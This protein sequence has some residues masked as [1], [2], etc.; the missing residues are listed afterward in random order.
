MHSENPLQAL[1]SPLGSA[2]VAA[3]RQLVSEDR[4][5]LQIM[6]LLHQQ[7]SPELARQ[8]LEQA[9]LQRRAAGKFPE[10]AERL[11]LLPDALEQASRHEVA[12]HRAARLADSGVT[13]IVDAGAGIGADTIAFAHHGIAVTAI[14]QDPHV[15]AAL[16]ANVRSLGLDVDVR[17]GDLQQILPSIDRTVTVYVDPARR[18]DGRRIF[19]PEQCR[20]PLSYL[21]SLPNP[22]VAKMSPGISYADLPSG[23]EA[24]WVSTFTEQGRSV[25][26]ACLWSPG[27][28][29][30]PRRAS[31]IARTGSV[32]VSGHADHDLPV[33][34]IG[35]YVYEPDGAINRAELAQHIA[36]PAR[37]TLIAPRI[38]Y[39]TADLAISTKLAA[40]FDVLD[41][42]PW[43]QRKLSAAVAAYELSDIVVKKRGIDLDP[44]RVRKALLPKKRDRTAEALVVIVCRRSHDSVAI[45]A[46]SAP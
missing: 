6:S 22:V 40:R 14:E 23:W 28:H 3:A 45:I 18:A 7:Y 33:G 30:A 17:V 16:R 32:S 46:R 9:I 31:I 1:L 43:S 44:A 4:T 11:I 2:A 10:F 13:R 12:N 20:P 5:T 34:P 29:S 39:L 27:L 15:A 38:G 8:A 21:Q 25:V 37:A 35:R 26:E 19:D 24:E 36:K 42:L 41:V